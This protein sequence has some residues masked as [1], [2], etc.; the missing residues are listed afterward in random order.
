MLKKHTMRV[1]DEELA[2]LEKAII[3]M[4]DMAA[5]QLDNAVLA[6][7]NRDYTLAK[8]VIERDQKVNQLQASV[9]ACTLRLLAMRQPMAVDLRH[10]LASSRM[11]SDLERIADYASSVAKRS[12]ELGENRVKEP[13]NIIAA[14]GKIA[15]AMLSKVA[16]AYQ[17]SDPQLAVEIWQQDQEI[18]QLYSQVIQTLSIL[19]SGEPECVEPCIALLNA[20]RAVERI[21]DHVTN[22][23]EHIYFMATGKVYIPA[24]ED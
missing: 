21:G 5:N 3:R 17:D 9:D 1:F 6:L 23:A 24:A 19:M 10:I 7:S 11:A 8:E 20:S 16:R 18:D 12:L 14:M 22:L 15:C 4:I 13:V 2:K